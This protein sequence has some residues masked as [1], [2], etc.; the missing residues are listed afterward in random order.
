MGRAERGRLSQNQL[1][2][3]AWY[4]CN[5]DVERKHCTGVFLRKARA[6]GMPPVLGVYVDSHARLTDFGANKEIYLARLANYGFMVSDIQ[7]RLSREPRKRAKRD[8]ADAPKATPPLPELTP[9]EQAHVDDLVRDLPDGLKKSVSRAVSMS[10]RR[11]KN[12]NTKN[13]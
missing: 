7:F 13:Q 9:S 8:V 10:M 5:G 6:E 3:R 1:A 4:G 2:A 11:N 12:T